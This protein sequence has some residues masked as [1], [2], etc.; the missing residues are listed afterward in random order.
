MGCGMNFNR[1]KIFPNLV[2]FFQFG[3]CIFG[4]VERCL[5]CGNIL[6]NWNFFLMMSSFF[7]CGKLFPN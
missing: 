1:E 6:P 2:K 4:D 7:E 5:N 3:K